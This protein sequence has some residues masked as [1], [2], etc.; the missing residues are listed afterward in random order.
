MDGSVVS[1]SVLMFGWVCL[2]GFSSH[3]F[4]FN[5]YIGTG[6]KYRRMLKRRQ[7]SLITNAKSGEVF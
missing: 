5:V 1:E 3:L 2:C 6:T 7:F 4:D